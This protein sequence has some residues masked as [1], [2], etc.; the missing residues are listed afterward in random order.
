MSTSTQ[1]SSTST[2]TEYYMSGINRKSVCDFLYVVIIVTDISRTGVIAALLVKFWTLFA[3]LSHRLG[4]GGGGR[5]NVRCPSLAHL[6]A[7]TG[8]PIS[9]N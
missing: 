7:R 5:D 1:T 9:V 4:G 3:L 6:K 8:L 2:S